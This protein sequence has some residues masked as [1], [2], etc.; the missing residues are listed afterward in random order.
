[1]T[2]TNDDLR[3]KL[4]TAWRF[5]YRRG[6]VDGFGHISARTQDPNVVLMTPHDL[7]KV[8]H[9]EDFVLCDLDGKQF[10]T[11]VKLPGE[12]PI[13]LEIFKS[14]PDVGAVAHFH[15]HYSSSFGMSE[16]ALKPT[17]FLASIF[18][19]GIPVHPDSRLILNQDRGEAMVRTL[20]SRRAM[21]LKAHGIVVTG[22]DVEEMAAAVYIMEDNAKRT[23]IAASMGKFETLGEAAMEEIEEELMRTRG[24]LGR[25]WKLC[26]ME[27]AEMGD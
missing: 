8:S 25:I 7:G 15:C 1:M 9:P 20:G 16:H 26:E 4:S 3:R 10:G 24:P 13:H 12:L 22:A 23:A 11:D 21:I 6:F 2:D 27:A 17:Y 14:R 5:F 18:R 19:D